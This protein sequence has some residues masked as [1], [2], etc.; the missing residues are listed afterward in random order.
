MSLDK[1]DMMRMFEKMAMKARG[2]EERK[3]KEGIERRMMEENE[4]RRR[5]EEEKRKT[6]EDESRRRIYHE[7]PYTPSFGSGDS[8]YEGGGE[9]RRRDKR[10]GREDRRD[11]RK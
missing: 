3:A 5:K 4:R 1:A 8:Y 10:G 11:G 2:E 7:R 9:G 6:E